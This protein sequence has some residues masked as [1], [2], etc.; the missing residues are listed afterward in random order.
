MFSFPLKKDTM[1]LFYD[2]IALRT[3]T[4][5]LEPTG[6]GGVFDFFEVIYRDEDYNAYVP[7]MMSGLVEDDPK[8][9]L[10]FDASGN[11]RNEDKRRAYY[12]NH[13]RRRQMSDH[14]PLW[15]ELK[16]DFGFEYL[17]NRMVQ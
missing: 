14:L 10:T 12:C 6:R 5:N 1:P 15:L 7:L 4:K 8:N 3:R 9:K 16:I 11:P 17:Q 13:W 2:Q